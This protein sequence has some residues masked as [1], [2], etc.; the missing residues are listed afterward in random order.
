MSGGSLSLLPGALLEG[1]Q[2]KGGGPRAV[3]G[4]LARLTVILRGL[5]C[6]RLPFGRFRPAEAGEPILAA[7]LHTLLSH[8]PPMKVHFA[9]TGGRGRATT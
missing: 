8:Q 5:V 6:A 9:G 1:R 3:F 2:T 4:A 7:R